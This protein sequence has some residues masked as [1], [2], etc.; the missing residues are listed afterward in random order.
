MNSALRISEAQDKERKEGN[1]KEVCAKIHNST[2]QRK[3]IIFKNRALQVP[4]IIDKSIPEKL[5]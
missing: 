4:G 1:Y 5:D 2:K 3:Y